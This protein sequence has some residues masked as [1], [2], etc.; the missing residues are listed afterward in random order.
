[1]ALGENRVTPI[2]SVQRVDGFVVAQGYEDGRAFNWMIT[3]STGMT[4]VTISR[5]GLSATAFGVCTPKPI[6]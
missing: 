5:E 4:T 2:N 1:M 3:E 6:E